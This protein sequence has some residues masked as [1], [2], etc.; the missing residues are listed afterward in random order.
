MI[1]ASCATAIDAYSSASSFAVPTS[2]IKR[3]YEYGKSL[4]NLNV[5]DLG[6]AESSQNMLYSILVTNDA[7]PKHRRSHAFAPPTCREL[8]KKD[9]TLC[10]AVNTNAPVEPI[11]RDDGKERTVPRVVK[12]PTIMLEYSLS[13]SELTYIMSSNLSSDF[14]VVAR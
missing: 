3:N 8:H 14:Y 4:Y 9:R 11:Q 2:L 10:L 13:N 6:I 1:Y 7:A 5:D 12:R